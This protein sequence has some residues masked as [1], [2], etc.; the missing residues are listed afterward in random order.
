MGSVETFITSIFDLCPKL[1]MNSLKRYGTIIIICV[2]Y[3]LMGIIFTLQ[4]GT[5]WLE[6]FNTFSGNWAIFIIAG[7]ESLSVAW[8][9]GFDNFRNDL[10]AMLGPK[11]VYHFS[12]NLFRILWCF[13]TPLIVLVSTPTSLFSINLD[14]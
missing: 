6:I 13:I 11:I 14:F 12:F 8:F 9:Y 10:A 4:S 5:Y 3:F 2:S 7:L 1:R